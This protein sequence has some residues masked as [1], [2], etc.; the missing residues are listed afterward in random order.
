MVRRL[1]AVF[2]TLLAIGLAILGWIAWTP[3]PDIDPAALRARAARHDVRIIRDAHGVPHVYGHRDADVAFGLAYAHAE[4]DWPT[5]ETVILMARGRLAL[6]DGASAAPGDYLLRLFRVRETVDAGYET[7]L[8]PGTRAL[9]EAYADGLNLWAAEHPAEA[10]SIALPVTGRDVVA[11]FVF[12]TP[13]FYGLEGRLAGLMSGRFEARPAIGL[14]PQDLES[15]ERDSAALDSGMRRPRRTGKADDGPAHAEASRAPEW[16]RS[17]GWLLKDSAAWS[18]AEVA[19]LGRTAFRLLPGM[20]LGSNAVAVAP[21]RSADGHT[22]LLVNSHQPFTGPVAW[23]EARLHS[24]E[25]WNVAGGLFPGAP[26]ILVGTNPHLGWAHTVNMPD[27]IDTYLL[28]VDDLEQPHRYRFAGGWREFERRDAAIR[29]RLFGPFSWEVHRPMLWSV[30]GP[31][32]KTPKGYVA[33]AWAGRN[34]IRSVEQ[35]YRMNRARDLGEWM[36]AMRMNAIPSLNTVYADDRGHIAFVYNARIPRRRPGHDYGRELLPGDDPDLLWKDYLPFDAVPKLVDPAAGFIISANADPRRVTGKGDNLRDADIPPALGVEDYL[37]NRAMRALTL[38]GGDREITDDEFVA[39]KFDKTYDPASNFWRFA[40]AVEAL[41][42]AGDPL[43]EQAQAL[44]RRWSGR[45][46]VEDPAA[47]LVILGT[48]K[49]VP[50]FRFEGWA[51][52]PREA[53]R[54]TAEELMRTHGRLDVPWGE[55]NRLRRGDV[56]LPLG[57]GPDVLRAIY[58]GNHPGP[59]GQLTAIAG[60]SYIMVVDWDERGVMQPLRTVHQFGAATSRPHS[61]HY[62]DQTALFAA[63]RFKVLPFD[64]ASLRKQAEREYRPGREAGLP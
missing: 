37:T 3:K 38:Y 64:L 48:R 20:R 23:Y 5:I 62:A 42:V 27:L 26:L 54:R 10:H 12:R 29:V 33:L 57:G 9:V 56:D 22:R 53:L 1:L 19:A 4:D 39:Y 51:M 61:P 32:L 44:V 21:S 50:G 8:A 43:L 28:E 35:W 30:H 14:L 40:T 31:V 55:V 6:R 59:D 16:P 25:G 60:D 24:D 34:E 11:G 47:A 49:A 15:G 46:V 58:G 2:A 17:W 18:P 13:F 45:A 63:E 41:D 52:P 7:Q 36:A